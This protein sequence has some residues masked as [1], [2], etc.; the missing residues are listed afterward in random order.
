M[1]ALVIVMDGVGVGHAPDA[2]NF[3]DQGADTLGHLFGAVRDLELPTLFS[4]GLGEIIKGRVFDPPARKCAAAYGRMRHRTAGKDS[5][6]GHWEL[7]GAVN[8]EPFA[9]FQRCPDELVA[10]IAAEAKVDFIGNYAQNTPGVLIDCGQEHLWTRRP[11][12]FTGPGSAIRIAGHEHSIAATQLHQICRIA[13]RHCNAQ[14]IRSVIAVPFAGSPGCWTQPVPEH[15][16]ALVPP[17]TILNAISETGLPVEAVGKVSSIFARSGITRSH[18]THSNDETLET[19]E[20]IWHSPQN[21]MI[22]ANLGDFGGIFGHRRDPEGFARALESFDDWLA[23]FLGEIDSDDL[24]VITADHGNDPTFHG[25]DHTREEVPVIVRYN[26][27]TGPLGVRETA[28]DVA[29]TLAEFFGLTRPGQQ[30]GEGVPLVHFHRP[31]G[32]GTTTH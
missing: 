23:D 17:R 31:D 26:G 22:F 20:R 30:W 25:T 5:A 4:L 10:A 6:S 1:R 27:R 11:I 14:R 13:R 15:D 3:N 28:S 7:A 21:G 32:A 18:A 29:A 12:L 8:Y 19:I 2:A 24:L 16:Y 9:E